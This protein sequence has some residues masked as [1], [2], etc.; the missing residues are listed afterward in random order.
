MQQQSRSSRSK[1]PPR[2]RPLMDEA[3][4]QQGFRSARHSA[5]SGRA[6]RHRDDKD[7]D[8]DSVDG[9]GGGGGGG[10]TADDDEFESDFVVDDRE[11]EDGQD[12]W[13]EDEDLEQLYKEQ[14]KKKK[15]QSK[16]RSESVVSVAAV[17][18]DGAKRRRLRRILDDD[19]DDRNDYAECADDSAANRSRFLAPLVGPASSSLSSSSSSSL[20][21]GVSSNK[22]A[23]PSLAALAVF[24]F[25]GRQEPVSLSAAATD[26]TAVPT[27]RSHY[28]SIAPSSMSAIASRTSKHDYLDLTQSPTQVAENAP[29]PPVRTHATA[30]PPPT[31][32]H[33]LAPRGAVSLAKLLGE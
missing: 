30:L 19:D 29:Q 8:D 14:K 31:D 25:S 16:S 13:S 20:S 7:D 4:D 15:K 28:F 26:S 18:E 3:H 17:S 1:R 9:D 33:D 2:P 10:G 24:K 23:P 27:V 21:S 12:V 22:L 32:W 11:G 6:R 5:P